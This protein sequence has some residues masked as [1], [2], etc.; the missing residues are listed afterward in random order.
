M[1]WTAIPQG[2]SRLLDSERPLV[3]GFMRPRRGAV[4]SPALRVVA[5]GR[6]SVFGF[7]DGCAQDEGHVVGRASIQGAV[8]KPFRCLSLG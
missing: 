2:C 7:L 3:A 5:L 6:R 4:R 1:P 8:E